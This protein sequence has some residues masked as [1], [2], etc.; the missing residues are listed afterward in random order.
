MPPVVL[1]ARGM[2]CPW[3]VLRLARVMR[4]LPPGGSVRL[5]ADDPAAP[6]EVAALV[7]ERGWR[8]AAEGDGSWLITA[9]PMA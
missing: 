4:A 7:S 5:H 9:D 6:R 2:R 1:D 3:P 8:M